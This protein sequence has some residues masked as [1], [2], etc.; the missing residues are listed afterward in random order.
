MGFYMNPLINFLTWEELSRIITAMPPEERGQP[1]VA[2]SITQE[3]CT[4]AYWDNGLKFADFH[5]DPEVLEFN[6]ATK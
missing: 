3:N 4:H 1:V 2:R 5:L 6:D